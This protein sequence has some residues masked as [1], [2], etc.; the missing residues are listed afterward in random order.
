M[1]YTGDLF[2][3]KGDD[4]LEKTEPLGVRYVALCDTMSYD[5]AT[6]FIHFFTVVA[7]RAFFDTVN[8]Q[9]RQMESNPKRLL[10]LDKINSSQP[11]DLQ[12][13]AATLSFL[14]LRR[15]LNSTSFS[16]YSGLRFELYKQIHLFYPLLDHLVFQ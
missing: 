10:I 12:R 11:L 4:A 14:S 6:V 9:N 1:K 2:D 13:S 16:S 7:V 15:C 5:L 8:N 3:N